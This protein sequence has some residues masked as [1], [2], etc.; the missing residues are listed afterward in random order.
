MNNFSKIVATLVVSTFF[1]GCLDFGEDVNIVA[2]NVT[3]KE[4]EIVSQRT[5]IIFSE[6]TTGL[7]YFF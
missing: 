6:G 2:P 7:G 4:L 1:Y 5:G 3:S